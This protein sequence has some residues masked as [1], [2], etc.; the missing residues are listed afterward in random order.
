[1]I[2]RYGEKNGLSRYRWGKEEINR[3][4]NEI[5]RKK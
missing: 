1:M 3:E 5:I 2:I 4:R